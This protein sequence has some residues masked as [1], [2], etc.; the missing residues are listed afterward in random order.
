M[1]RYARYSLATL[2][3]V[4]AAICLALAAWVNRV[5]FQERVIAD[6]EALGG[7]VTS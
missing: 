3:T 4:V 2:G 6:I 7:N 5:H 1:K